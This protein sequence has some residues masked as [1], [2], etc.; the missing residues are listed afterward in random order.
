M[1]IVDQKNLYCDPDLIFWH[2]APQEVGAVGR[3]YMS[4][5]SSWGRDIKENVTDLQKKTIFQ[6]FPKNSLGHIFCVKNPHGLENDT[7]SN[8][9]DLLPAENRP[10]RWV[11]RTKILLQ[12]P[13]IFEISVE[14]SML[15][16]EVCSGFPAS[17]RLF[18]GVSRLF[19]SKICFLD[20]V[21]VLTLAIKRWNPAT[22]RILQPKCEPK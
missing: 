21:S 17:P 13:D 5:L 6:M 16:V 15:A 8:L 9:G 14:G 7:Y 19:H 3:T 20:E 22:M 11:A 4:A 1:N 18:R 12:I 2:L 10:I